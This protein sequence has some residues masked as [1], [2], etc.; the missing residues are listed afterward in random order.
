[1]KRGDEGWV[2]GEVPESSE[3]E[4]Y[5]MEY[6]MSLVERCPLDYD[7]DEDAFIGAYDEDEDDSD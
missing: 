4:E 7:D 2:I 1:M 5:G 6:L 3:V